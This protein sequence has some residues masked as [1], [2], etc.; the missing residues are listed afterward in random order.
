M[1]TLLKQ[2]AIIAS[3]DPHLSFPIATQLAKVATDNPQLTAPLAVQLAKIASATPDVAVP[4]AVQLAKIASATPDIAVPLAV[5]LAKVAAL[6][7]NI[8][9]SILDSVSTSQLLSKRW[10]A[11]CVEGK[12]LGCIFLCGGWFA[13]LLWEPTLQFRRCVSIDVDPVCEEVAK[14]IHKSLVMKD[15]K[16]QAVTDDIHHID[17]NSHTF[18]VTRSDGTSCGLIESPDTIINTSCEHI[19]NFDQWYASIPSGKLVILQ[20]N[21]G[22][23]IPGHVNCVDSLTQFAN[24]TPFATTIYSGEMEMPKF[25]RFMRIGYK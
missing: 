14:L 18:V 6:H 7:P 13:M 21:D 4:L 8:S 22:F 1:H 10:I 25:T 17:F 12:D 19:L 11:D 9:S 2:I 24:R 15:W 20:S 5:Q 16:F 23:D 3:A